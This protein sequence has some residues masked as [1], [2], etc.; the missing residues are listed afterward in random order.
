[1]LL[2]RVHISRILESGP[3][4][5]LEARHSTVAYRCPKWCLDCCTNH[6]PCPLA[7]F[8]GGSAREEFGKWCSLASPYVF[9]H[10]LS[11]QSWEP[12]RFRV[13]C[14]VREELSPTSGETGM[15]TPV[16]SWLT[17]FLGPLW[18]AGQVAGTQSYAEWGEVCGAQTNLKFLCP[19]V[20][21]L[22]QRNQ[23]K[24]IWARQLS[25]CTFE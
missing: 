5:E 14:W 15:W 11:E 17:E 2:P 23:L 10:T 18:R 16:S 8:V 6:L 3:E 12:E 24:Q 22:L 1:M 13:P 21:G 7:P 25:R 19:V 4:L 9:S 20:V